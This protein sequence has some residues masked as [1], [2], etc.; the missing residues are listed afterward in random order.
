MS[1]PHEENI[2]RFVDALRSGDYHQ[3]NQVLGYEEGGVEKFCC[4]GVA[5][6]VAIQ[7]GVPL[8]RTIGFANGRFDAFVYVATDDSGEER[9]ETKGVYLHPLVQGFYGFDSYNPSTLVAHAGNMNDN[10]GLSFAQ[11]AD[12]FEQTYLG[13]T[14]THEDKS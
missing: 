14:E 5:T 1:V 6:E 4:L 8:V 3:G 11:I 7:C 13:N 9:Q 10:M 2:R 12:A